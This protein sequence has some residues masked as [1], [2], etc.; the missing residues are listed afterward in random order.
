[1]RSVAKG[2]ALNSY[3]NYKGARNDLAARIGWFCSYCEMSVHNM[4][5]VEHIRPINKGGE[6]LDWENFL[7]SCRYCNS[8][9]KDR[10]DGR[11]GY[12]WPDQDNTSVAFTYSED[13]IIEPAP[14]LP[15]AVERYAQETIDLTGLNRAPHSGQKPTDTDSRWIKRIEV[16]GIIHDSYQDWLT[17]QSEVTARLIGWIASGHGFY[18]CWI[19]QFSDFPLVLEAINNSFSGTYRPV[20]IDGQL[21][22]RPGAKY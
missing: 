10:N 16:W 3:S 11:D 13:K 6:E 22:V 14:N 12:L 2:D 15:P 8:V 7:L 21:Q 4:I 17:N 1:M 9:K 19:K 18:S 20:Y 5:E